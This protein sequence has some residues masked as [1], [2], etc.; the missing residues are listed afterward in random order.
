MITTTSGEHAKLNGSAPAPKPKR[1][2]Y[3]QYRDAIM[4]STLTQS[5]KDVL[6]VIVA[7]MSFRKGA[8]PPF[9]G[10][11]RIAIM[12]SMG[13]R[14]VKRTIR[15]LQDRDILRV[16]RR[17]R[18]NRYALHLQTLQALRHPSL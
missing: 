16:E 10:Q 9:P 2:L 4:C 15:G 13:V 1:R 5:E 14:T 18:S 6:H 3:L 17:G 7:H 11:E 8:R 12:A